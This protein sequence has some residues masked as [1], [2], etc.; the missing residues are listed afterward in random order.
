MPYI[1][2]FYYENGRKHKC[3]VGPE[4]PQYVIHSMPV[5]FLAEP[6][7]WGDALLSALEGTVNN[8]RREG[9]QDVIDWLRRIHRELGD[10]LGEAEEERPAELVKVERCEGEGRPR[11]ARRHS[12]EGEALPA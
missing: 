5:A 9:R 12:E 7:R 2:G 4:D 11:E 3:Y 6:D 8:A 1:Y 10:L